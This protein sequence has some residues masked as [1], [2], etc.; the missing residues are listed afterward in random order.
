MGLAR[1][2]HDRTTRMPVI[3]LS[4]SKSTQV[5]TAARES[6]AASGVTEVKR[7]VSEGGH[8]LG[9]PEVRDYAEDDRYKYDGVDGRQMSVDKEDAD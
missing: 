9:V 3:S 7:S 5:V 4:K 1:M 8:A 2:R 6:N